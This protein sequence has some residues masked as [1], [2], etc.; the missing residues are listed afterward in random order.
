MPPE[1]PVEESENERKRTRQRDKR[2]MQWRVFIDRADVELKRF[3]ACGQGG[4]GIIE[5][6]LIALAMVSRN[7][8]LIPFSP[9]LCRISLRQLERPSTGL[10]KEA[11]YCPPTSECRA[12]HA[13]APDFA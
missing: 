12:E 6:H 5:H 4:L 13:G 7:E 8:P 9:V 11:D 1:D 3:Y 2:Q 10:N